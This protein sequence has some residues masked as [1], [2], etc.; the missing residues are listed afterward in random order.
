[1]KILLW[2]MSFLYLLY[3]MATI[4]FP[5]CDHGIMVYASLTIRFMH[6]RALRCFL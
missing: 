1:M 6:V 5:M 3:V 2:W 4:I